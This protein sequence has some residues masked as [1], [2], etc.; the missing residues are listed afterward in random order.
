MAAQT[1]DRFVSP[2]VRDVLEWNHPT[3]DYV[4]V[5]IDLPSRSEIVRPIAASVAALQS[6]SNQG[7]LDIHLLRPLTR[8]VINDDGL[9]HLGGSMRYNTFDEMEPLYRAAHRVNQRCEIEPGYESL[10]GTY[11][12]TEHSISGSSYVVEISGQNYLAMMHAF[13]LAEVSSDAR[14]EVLSNAAIQARHF[15]EDYEDVCGQPCAQLS[16]LVDQP[17]P[18][19]SFLDTRLARISEACENNW[20]ACQTSAYSLALEARHGTRQMPRDPVQ[21]LELL[22]MSAA[23]GSA[24]AHLDLALLREAPVTDSDIRARAVWQGIA[25]A[26]QRTVP[27]LRALFE[28]AAPITPDPEIA[29]DHHIAALEGGL[30]TMLA[31]SAADWPELTARALQSRLADRGL[32]TG[33]VDGRIGPGTRTAMEALCQCGI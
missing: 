3:T 18:G 16:D 31:R 7:Q 13:G 8:F 5:T 23:N 22:R 30:N 9:P 21:A 4:F 14:S 27:D 20:P 1:D 11:C 33:A 29:A 26:R 28:L 25:E 24:A 32:Y 2:R 19:V 10:V 17:T 15:C 12:P 6:A